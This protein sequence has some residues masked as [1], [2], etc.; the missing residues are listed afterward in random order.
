[1]PIS[2]VAHYL[3]LTDNDPGTDTA[4]GRGPPLPRQPSRG[5][6]RRPPPA[7][8]A[9]RL[10]A[11]PRR[12]PRAVTVRVSPPPGG[13]G[14]AHRGLVHREAGDRTEGLISFWVQWRLLVVFFA[15]TCRLSRPESAA[16]PEG[17]IV[18]R[19]QGVIKSWERP[20]IPGSPDLCSAGTRRT[21]GRRPP[22]VP[23]MSPARPRQP[24]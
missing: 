20:Q 2:A 15:K 5:T 18:A 1:M 3:R 10:R 13:T 22:P 16:R 21:A 11:V 17:E 14:P 12:E 7:R 24:P 6:V 8:P 4:F 19:P 9:P 23:T